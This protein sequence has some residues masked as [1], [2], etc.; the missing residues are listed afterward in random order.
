[1]FGG[2]LCEAEAPT[3][4]AA[5]TGETNLFKLR[6]LILD[7]GYYPSVAYGDSS[8]D[9]WSNRGLLYRRQSTNQWLPF[10]CAYVGAATSIGSLL[11]GVNQ[12]R[13]ELSQSD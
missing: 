12:N 2:Q 7:I 5:V 6:Y 9:K 13:G 1:M 11:F 4:A 8:P 3:E 10:L